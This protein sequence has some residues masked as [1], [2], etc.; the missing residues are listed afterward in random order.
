MLGLVG[1]SQ[2]RL[3]CVG[4]S[5]NMLGLVGQSQN[6]L[7]CVGQSQNRLV[8]VGLSKNMLGLVGQSQNRLDR[9]GLS[10]NRS[11]QDG[12]GQVMKVMYSLKPYKLYS[13]SFKPVSGKWETT[14]VKKLNHFK[15]NHLS[16]IIKKYVD[17]RTLPPS[18][19]RISL[20]D[21]VKLTLCTTCIGNFFFLF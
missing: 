1:Q 3:V 16:T 7:V 9:V 18:L 12:I 11:G 14:K 5:Q 19:K 4:L 13:Q 15:N 6:R 10:K 8:C 20:N 17:P 21:N 2:N